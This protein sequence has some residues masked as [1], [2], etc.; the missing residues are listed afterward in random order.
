[1]TINSINGPFVITAK[2]D[3]IESLKNGAISI[4]DYKTGTPPGKKE[5]SA[6][7]APQLPLEALIASK[8]IFKGITSTDVVKLSYWHLKGKKNQ[9]Q[10]KA[11]ASG[12]GEVNRLVETVE[13]ILLTLVKSFDDQSTTYLARS[14]PEEKERY[15]D[16]DHLSR[17]KEW[18]IKASDEHE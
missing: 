12:E 6:G 3:R 1:M 18:S 2:A 13:E 4:I 11:I 7:N 8:G 9:N 16:Y 15:S 17:I 10:I 14:H 5:V